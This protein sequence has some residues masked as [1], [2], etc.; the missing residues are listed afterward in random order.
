MSRCVGCTAV[1]AFAM[2]GIEQVEQERTVHGQGRHTLWTGDLGMAFHR[3]ARANC[4]RHQAIF[5]M[6]V[7]VLSLKVEKAGRRE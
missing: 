5:G 4:W 7:I 6:I 3:A 2:H 1:R